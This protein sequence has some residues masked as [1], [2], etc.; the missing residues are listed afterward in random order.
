MSSNY[1]FGFSFQIIESALTIFAKID[2]IYPIGDVSL[3][4]ACQGKFSLTGV[5]YFRRSGMIVKDIEGNE[6]VEII[7]IDEQAASERFAPITHYLIVMMVGDEYLLGWNKWR[8][9]WELFGGCMEAGETMR[10]CI[11]RECLEETGISGVQFDYIGLMRCNLVP[12][13]FSPEYRTEYGGLYGVKLPENALQ[14]IEKHRLD[15]EEIE[16]VALLKNIG[17]DERI[18]EIDKALLNYYGG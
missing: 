17:A 12:D 5:F 18:A 15:R 10:S 16:R 8:Q 2:I 11:V 6:L 13:Y 7:D 14:Y 9:R 3:L 4:H 1:I